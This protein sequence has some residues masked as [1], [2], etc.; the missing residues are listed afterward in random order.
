MQINSR[1]AHYIR[2]DLAVFDAP[3]FKISPNE[4]QTMDP[5]QR[6]LLETSYEALENAGIPLHT[7]QGKSVG[8][9]VGGGLSDYGDLLSRTPNNN[10][11]Y[12][13]TGMSLNMLANRISYSFDL[14]GPSLTLD[15]A[16]SSSLVAL[17]LACQSLKAGESSQAI[18]SGAYILLSPDTWIGM[19]NLGLHG[20]EGRCF[21]Y[22]HR[23]TGYGRGEGVASLILKPLQDAIE[24][25]DTIR[26][27]VRNTGTNQDGQ[28]NGITMPS[29]D[30]QEGLIRSVYA[31]AGLEP[32]RTHYVEAHGTGTK[33]GDPIEAEALSRAIALGRSSP[34]LVGSVKTNVG[35]LEAAS[36]IASVIK[37]VCM[38]ET[39]LVPPNINFEKPNKSIPLEQWNLK[40]P[41]EITPWP[42]NET[43]RASI[44]NFG[45]GGSNV[46]VILDEY[47]VS[48]DDVQPKMN[49][50]IG[51]TGKI[52]HGR[53]EGSQVID[54]RRLVNGNGFTEPHHSV[55]DGLSHLPK[56]LFLL[57]ASE[58]ASVKSQARGLADYLRR[59]TS[60][61]R[62]FMA[63]LAFTLAQRRSKL[64]WR[65]V[66]L[67]S[68]I[69]ELITALESEDIHLSRGLKV[70]S[71][72]F[73]F[74]G[75]GAQW[76]AMGLELLDYPVFAS[77]MEQA[78]A[79][80]RSLGAEWSL[81]DELA[82]T[83]AD[84]AINNARISQPATT[85][86][87][88]ALVELL[89]SWG[90]KPRAVV[91]HSSGEIAAAFSAGILTLESCMRIAYHRGTL[92]AVL[93][94]THPELVGGM[95]A[96][97][98]SSS[99]VEALIDRIT[100]SKVIVA[101]HNGPSLVTASGDRAGIV[102]LQQ[103]AEAEGLF[104]RLLQVDVAYHSH[105]M[106]YVAELYRKTL[107]HLDPSTE[108]RAGFYSS[109]H[110][111]RT[112]GKAL[113]TEYWVANLTH[114][115]QFT[116][117]L[118]QL[119]EH[120]QDAG[121]DMLIEIGPHAAL[122][123]PIQDLLK[124]SPG[125]ENGFRYLACLRRMENAQTTMLS[126]VAEL[127]SRGYPADLAGLNQCE[128][129]KVLVDLPPYP[130]LH[131]RRHWGESRV[132]LNH[133]VR[134]FPRND[135]LGHLLDDQSYLEPR[136]LGTIRLSELPWLRDHKVQS[137]VIFPLAAYLSMA[138]EAAY[139]QATMT[140]RTVAGGAKY[141]LR[142]VSVQ[143]SL[144]LT[145][146]SEPEISLTLKPQRT[147]SRGG[148]GKWN[149][150]AIYSWTQSAGWSEHCRGLI[151]VTADDGEPN[152]VDGIAAAEAKRA[153][154]EHTITEKQRL[155]T[156]PMSCD[157]YYKMTHDLGFQFGPCFQGLREALVAPGHAIAKTEI[158]NTA[159]TMPR[160]FESSLIINPATLDS[161]FHSSTAAI[162]DPR[163]NPSK[164]MVPTFMKSMSISHGIARTPGHI[165]DTCATVK[166]S[167]SGQQIEAAF[168]VVDADS[169]EKKSMIEIE[170]LISSALTTSHDG[171]LAQ[172]RDL[173]FSMQYTTCP[174]LLTSVQYCSEFQ[175][176]GREFQY[177]EQTRSAERAAFYFAQ[178]ALAELSPGDLTSLP[179]HLRRLHG[180]LE[181]KVKQALE[182]GLPY[183][184]SDW[185][186]S[187]DPERRA[188]MDTIES[189]SAFGE[190]ICQMG[191][192]L[193]GILRGEVDPST[194]M[195]K[196]SLIERYYESNVVL[197]Q[198]Y[199]QCAQWVKLLGRQN[200][201]MRILVIGAGT[202]QSTMHILKELT[203]D[204]S[205][206]PAFA[207]LD[208]T[209][210]SED[211]IERAT[212]KL[213][214]WGELVDYRRLDIANDPV[215][216][217]FRPQSYD[218]VFTSE[219]MR[220]AASIGNT[221]QHIRS[222]LKPGGKLLTV[223]TTLLTISDAIVFGSS[224][225]WWLGQDQRNLTAT[226]WDAELRQKKFSG[227]DGIIPGNADEPG[228]PALDAVYTSTAIIGDSKTFPTASLLTIGRP[229]STEVETLRMSLADTT[230]RSV[231][232]HD[233]EELEAD[234]FDGKHWVVLAL[235]DFSL[236]GLS[237]RNFEKLRS[238]L[239]HSQGV[240]WVTC[241]ARGIAPEAGMIDGLARVVRSENA[242]VH[243]ATL[244]LD[245]A[246][247]L[248]P[249]MTADV[250]SR[251]YAYVF[252]ANSQ[253]LEREFVE[254]KGIIKIRRV[255]G[256]EA[257]DRYVMRETQ[258]PL[259]EPQRFM[260]ED[261][262]LQLKLGRPGSLDSIYF[263]DDPAFDEPVADDEVE[264][265]IK[266]TGMNFKDVMIGL[267]QVPFS[268]MG[269]EC[270]GV[271]AAIG[272]DVKNFAVGDRVCGLTPG[273]YGNAVRARQSMLGKIP[274]TLGFADAASIPVVFCTA[275][276]ALVEIARLVPGESVLIHAAAGG[277]GQAAI[278]VAQHIGD[279]EIF[280][281]IGS[282]Q[283]KAFLVENY[284][285]P[286][287]NIFSSRDTHF[288]EGVLSQTKG[289]GVDVVLNSLAGESLSL[290][291]QRCLA[292]LGRFIEI[293]KRDLAVNST[294]EM[295]KFLESVT[296]AGVDLGVFAALKPGAFNAMFGTILNLHRI[297]AF[298]PVS[299]ITTFNMSGLQK[300][301]RLM[302]SGKHLGK[303]VISAVPSDIV[304]VMPR[305][306]PKV[307]VQPGATYLITGGT[308]GAGRSIARWLCSQGAK[309]ILL[310]SRSG[311]SQTR[312]RELVDELQSKGVGIT[313]YTCDIGEEV[314]VKEMLVH[315]E[316]TMPPIRGIIHGAMV[317]RDVLFEKATSDDWEA[318][319]KA[320][321]QGTWN[322]HRCTLARNTELDFF[323]MLGS[324]S[325]IVGNRGQAAYSASNTFMDAFEQYRRFQGLPA[326]TIDLGVL[327]DVGIVAE[328][329][330]LR[331]QM[332]G[333]GHDV[334]QER[335]LLALIKAGINLNPKD[336]HS[337]STITGCK[338]VAGL[339]LPWWAADPKFS[340]LAR[341]TQMDGGNVS[342]ED[343][344]SIRD[345][346]KQASSPA[347]VQARI[348]EALVGKLAAL[349]MTPAE[350]V[351]LQKPMTAYGMDSL[352][353]VE[354]RN[355]IATEMA[356]NIPALEFLSSSSL[357][358]LSKLI[359]RK[360]TLIEQNAS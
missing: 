207:K 101:C 337:G 343:S 261:R 199:Q 176:H 349:S 314:Q 123:A 100:D 54:D 209:D 61:D 236:Q 205:Q 155:C 29:K 72:G 318:V 230:H 42:S 232:I 178:S 221:L 289:K 44:N 111:N 315:A 117:A 276:Y 340:H 250:I 5:Q 197:D 275:Y 173:C 356:A 331:A 317:N 329:K 28:T 291:W 307:A 90:I 215:E 21:A 310:A 146:S 16:C 201:Q 284:G 137:S 196:D 204:D 185:V 91:G 198:A 153:K 144:V 24:A 35:H 297:G 181:S 105:H 293:G 22:D 272:R 58:Q 3:F 302:Q 353:A 195:L 170:G 202:G 192:N 174:D 256:R 309:S 106:D 6:L 98:A 114:P 154:I 69:K 63:D 125:W 213:K 8:V 212:E 51:D 20:E 85:A 4:A 132:G 17:H 225:D 190:L 164:V 282:L 330:E 342:N 160:N 296:F 242:G 87:Q 45:F 158:P 49:G 81:L 182:N 157:F 2:Q 298:V 9:Y 233:F 150:F 311:L 39:G 88:I 301:M 300:A 18:V 303:V 67:A 252:E 240:L 122:K 336:L 274:E 263:M 115:V 37:T 26:A 327:A 93:K 322:L 130:W 344:I 247:P 326:S 19:S 169:P 281:T 107:G 333:F 177:R 321:V 246:S 313:V 25:G 323:I 277:V 118:R 350:D 228:E 360:S 312:T 168:L 219:G 165:F 186:P 218:L 104:A 354:M 162:Y 254:D 206:V 109:L 71:L 140:G 147:G 283:K 194:I 66:A 32:S 328:D 200:P 203:S 347:Q 172:R 286:E 278:M 270:S 27:V 11:T 68:S 341:G 127:V 161:C 214:R 210:R 285:I 74:T 112:R 145:E 15:T 295:E 292:P 193:A 95:L 237:A 156:T 238:L 50:N 52:H 222:L 65:A 332:Q 258:Q 288:A 134:P 260:Q 110:G 57:T 320:R 60:P 249:P 141:D 30:A 223:E 138:V 152:E 248:T 264:M 53:G 14:Q 102:Q 76:P 99:K 73:V 241:G 290:S 12:S 124:V 79:C 163:I 116:Q 226:E 280:A 62:G 235:A 335:E 23:G 33:V 149:E 84:S 120:E 306:D 188:F 133:R 316:R 325:G 77:A 244:D 34:L 255:V 131:N 36:G 108:E 59:Q 220:T 166:V 189:S 129:R 47:R 126:T 271:V 175:L 187:G 40:I 55:K 103:M 83:G 334:V 243:L 139:Q 179:D 287:G 308:G 13:A 191:K 273:G 279:V 294:L 135:L 359:V 82:K 119:C 304:Q 324:L 113:G 121:V 217:G 80:L 7:L 171:Q 299:P 251:T 43:R 346:L 267:G 234:G 97:G 89:R 183:Q 38:L 357:A 351:D 352:V 148:P 265:E 339:P 345:S 167:R 10:A 262:H 180:L 239:L 245:G 257:E 319:V 348:E 92:A 86:I 48:N 211:L 151:T 355:W 143:R 305:A 75:Q 128:S 266:A 46:H 64:E 1:G 259:P 229:A 224:P 142:Q 358:G 184:S 136:W 269:L 31:A 231:D 216:Q 41:T 338:L 208:F 70:P 96:I 268:D 56:R 159:A 227:I 253:T 94:E 78:D